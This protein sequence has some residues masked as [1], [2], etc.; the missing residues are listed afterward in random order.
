MSTWTENSNL[1]A[2][3]RELYELN[4]SKATVNVPATPPLDVT[5]RLTTFGLAWADLHPFAQQAVLWDMG[6][7]AQDNSSRINQVLTVCGSDN[8]TGIGMDSIAVSLNAFAS[9]R[10]DETVRLCQHRG[11]TEYARQETSDG[12]SLAKVTKC[13]WIRVDNMTTCN[14][15]MW[16]QD[17]S[18]PLSVPDPHLRYHLY[19]TADVH[20]EMASIQNRPRD[21]WEVPWGGCPPPTN[22]GYLTIP[23]VIYDNVTNATGF[24][25]PA[26]TSLMDQ[27][28]QDIKKKNVTI[29]GTTPKPT[30]PPSVAVGGV[31][32]TNEA[33]RTIADVLVV[34]SL[35]AVAAFT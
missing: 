16:S 25:K 29:R 23:C 10:P 14:K 8:K 1:V 20:W 9:T 7:V 24:C 6:L 33:T 11:D 28:L 15:S 35:V 26:P 31:A 34:A 4:A 32:P 2:R 19:D 27:W 5:S 30:M 18:W 13:A 3:F 12:R 21:E 22:P 17:S